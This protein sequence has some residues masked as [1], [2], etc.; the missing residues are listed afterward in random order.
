MPEWLQVADVKVEH[1]D[2]SHESQFLQDL[3]PNDDPL[4]SFAD[5]FECP[6]TASSLRLF[7][8]LRVYNFD[9]LAN[10]EESSVYRDANKIPRCSIKDTF[11]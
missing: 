4:S 6:S 9:K 1:F 11:V 8:R 7:S 3:L 5:S 10:N 2:D